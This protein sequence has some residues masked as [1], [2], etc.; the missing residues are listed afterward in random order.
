MSDLRVFNVEDDDLIYVSKYKN[1]DLILFL[2]HQKTRNYYLN[3]EE[4]C[5]K[6]FN[7][8]DLK[9]LLSM[10]K[11]DVQ[12]FFDYGISRDS[13]LKALLMHLTSNI[14]KQE[15]SIVISSIFIPNHIRFDRVFEGMFC[16]PKYSYLHP[17]KFV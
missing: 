8:I 11:I 14:F 5:E 3:S 15:F 2:Y 12:G 16:E 7:H 10:D 4:I 6:I 9:Y 17:Y 1:E 13:F